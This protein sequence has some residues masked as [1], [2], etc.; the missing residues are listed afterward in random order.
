MT[1]TVSL[2]AP[3]GIAVDEHAAPPALTVDQAHRL[4]QVHLECT[5][6]NCGVRQTALTLLV[7]EKHYVLDLNGRR[8]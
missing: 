5:T 8:R 1:S 4:M 3:A 2:C 7:A 6:A